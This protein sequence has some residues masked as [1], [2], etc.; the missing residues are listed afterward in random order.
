MN[1]LY[2]EGTGAIKKNVI[3]GNGDH[4]SRTLSAVELDLIRRTEL[5]MVEL[6]L[7]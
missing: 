6:D 2:E 5:D 1:F 4:D 3:Y 7:V